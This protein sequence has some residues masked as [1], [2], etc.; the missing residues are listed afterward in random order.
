MEELL[1]AWNVGDAK[2]LDGLIRKTVR[3]NPKL[4][5]VM[6]ALF[7]DRNAKMFEKIEKYLNADKT[8]FVV[9]GAGHVVGRTGIVRLLRD[10]GLT[11]KQ[12]RKRQAAVGAG[13]R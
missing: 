11:V 13:A 10:K 5:P 7:D 9:V 12:I 1:E 4:R 3:E 8:F 6:K 2:R